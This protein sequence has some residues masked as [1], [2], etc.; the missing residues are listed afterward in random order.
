MRRPSPAT[1]FRGGHDPG[2]TQP[3]SRGMA[4][5][6][7]RR[8]MRYPE[9]FDVEG[10]VQAE[11]FVVWLANDHLELTGPCGPLPG[12]SSSG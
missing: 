4:A 2:L 5:A 7:H 8:V 11:V 1:L 9:G 6:Y 12:F 10:P 3:E